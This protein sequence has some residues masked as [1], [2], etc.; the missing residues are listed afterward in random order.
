MPYRKV[1]SKMESQEQNKSKKFPGINLFIRSSSLFLLACCA[2]YIFINFGNQTI[3]DDGDIPLVLV[4]THDDSDR[5]NQLLPV[6]AFLSKGD[7]QAAV[8]ILSRLARAGNARAAVILSRM[9]RQGFYI[10]LSED[11]HCE[12]AALADELGDPGGAYELGICL[13]DEAE[14]LLLFQSALSRGSLRAKA[15]FSCG[16]FD[17]VDSIVD[18]DW[19]KIY[20]SKASSNNPFEIVEAA[21]LA[22]LS[23]GTNK[24]SLSDNEV[25]ALYLR[26]AELGLPEGYYS[27]G[28]LAGI[29]DSIKTQKYHKLAAASNFHY[30]AI[31]LVYSV[32]VSGLQT[33]MSAKMA[34]RVKF[35]FETAKAWD[36][37]DTC[38]LGDIY[39]LGVELFGVEKNESLAVSYLKEC[40]SGDFFGAA[41][42]ANWLGIMYASGIGVPQNYDVSLKFYLKAH[43]MGDPYAA[44]NIGEAYELGEGYEVD[45]EEALNWY[46]I[47]YEKLKNT[48]HFG[49]SANTLG[50]FY[51][52]GMGVDQDYNRA[53]FYYREALESTPE[54]SPMPYIRLGDLIA[55]GYVQGSK[56]EALELYSKATKSFPEY[57]N[58]TVGE[59]GNTYQKIAENKRR[60]LEK[61]Q[62]RKSNDAKSYLETGTYHALLF[63]VEDY[64]KLTDLKTPI[65]DVRDLAQI[66]ASRYGFSTTVV[67]NPTRRQIL[68]NISVL[69]SALGP[70]DNLLIYYAGHGHLDLD[71]DTG[72]WQAA[73]ADPVDDL[74]WIPTERITRTLRAIKSN[75]ILVIADS[76]FSGTL[77]RGG[78][79]GT[80]FSAESGVIQ[81]L[82]EEKTRVAFTSGGLAPVAD[83]LLGGRNSVF[84]KELIAIL[85]Q[86]TKPLSATDLFSQVRS[87]VTSVSNALGFEQSP[88][89]SNLI[90][91]GHKGGDFVFVQD[92]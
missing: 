1:M 13:T 20:R 9:Y 37:S 86:S 89:F 76:C 59:S 73:D 4:E 88:Q 79:V 61:R 27:L 2:V 39:R 14:S 72:F 63:G 68:Q 92:M 12:Y 30:S 60:N 48:G 21:D 53:A 46:K 7:I 11:L 17:A 35:S 70:K 51:E 18:D 49:W 8:L 57:E 29:E 6:A 23:C 56:E 16:E 3:A 34:E 31:P 82:I 52:N 64:V 28:V 44:G 42:S 84:A 58:L 78:S 24:Y 33:P 66:L 32:A 55:Q 75:N 25:A 47:S 69:R 83:N 41:S 81:R 54:A 15:S 80:K 10:A 71:T 77:L 90:R 67:E 87:R 65:S 38:Y 40:L 5:V 50:R 36:E 26:A 43:E 91:S 45:Y 22:Y 19:I 62:A 74:D 85:Q